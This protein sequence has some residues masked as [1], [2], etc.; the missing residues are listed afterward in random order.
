MGLRP[1]LSECSAKLVDN[2]NGCRVVQQF[3]AQERTFSWLVD[4]MVPQKLRDMLIS[5]ASLGDA[6]LSFSHRY[7]NVAL[8]FVQ[9]NVQNAV[10]AV[11]DVTRAAVVQD[12]DRLFNI[13]DDILHQE[14]RA[15]KVET[16]SGECKSLMPAPT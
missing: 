15:Y 8:L 14:P 1:G 10:A 3:T 2:W 7:D 5:S 6:A 12:L 9:L 11:N 16:V 13:L 4:A